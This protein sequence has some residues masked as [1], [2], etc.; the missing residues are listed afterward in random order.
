MRGSLSGR[1]QLKKRTE[2]RGDEL[3]DFHIV[4]TGEKKTHTNNKI[5]FFFENMGEKERDNRVR[6]VFVCFSFEAWRIMES[7]L[8][9]FFT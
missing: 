6:F 2:E 7:T 3:I 1:D 9:N 5:S 8:K 4:C